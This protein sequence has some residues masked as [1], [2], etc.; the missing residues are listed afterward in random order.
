[1]VAAFI[2]ENRVAIAVAWLKRNLKIDAPLVPV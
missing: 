1:M 2:V